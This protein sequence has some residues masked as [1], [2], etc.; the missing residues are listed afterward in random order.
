MDTPVPRANTEESGQ[1]Q[2]CGQT[3]RTLVVRLPEGDEHLEDLEWQE[4]GQGDPQREGWGLDNVHAHVS[5]T[6]LCMFPEFCTLAE[7]L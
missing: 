4:C 5:P 3:V 1:A 2:I 7:S 6:S